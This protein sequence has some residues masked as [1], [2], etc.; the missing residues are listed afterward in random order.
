MKENE[1]FNILK[2]NIMTKNQKLAVLSNERPI[3]VSASA[4]SGK[5]FVLTTR[6]LYKILFSK[7]PTKPNKILVLTFAKSAAEEM[8]NRIINK[9]NNISLKFPKNKKINDVKNMISKNLITTIDS[10]CYNILKENFEN[11]NISPNFKIVSNLEI[12]PVKKEILNNIFE[13]EFLKNNKNFKKL[14]NYFSLTDYNVLKN[15]ILKIYDKS[16]TMPFPKEYIK[17]LIKQYESPPEFYKSEFLKEIKEDI[18]NKF[19]EIKDLLFLTINH[20]QN[21]SIEKNITSNIKETIKNIEE[22]EQNINKTKYIE[23]I[24]L[25]NNFKI[26]NFEKSENC[27]KDLIDY[28]KK[29]Y[30]NPAKKI[31]SS[32]KEYLISEEEYL[33]DF[34]QQKNIVKQLINLTLKFFNKLEIKKRKNNILEFSDLII[35]TIKLLT[36]PTKNNKFELSKIGI[37]ISKKFDEIL[38]D[39]FQDINNS[40]D[41]LIRILSNDEN[42][43]FLVG[44]LKQSIYKFRNA[45]PSIFLNKKQKYEN[46][47]EKTLINLNENFRS[48]K[49]V[50]N[51]VNFLFGQIMSSNFGGV[52][53]KNN[54]KL[55]SINK[56]K[57][58]KEYSTELHILN[59]TEKKF[60]NLEFEINHVAKT[61]KKM[62]DEEFLIYDENGNKR[63]C[64]PK[65]F[66]VLFRTGKSAIN[67][68]CEKLLNLNINYVCHNTSN[69][70][71]SF[72][73]TLL[74]SLLKTINNPLK[75]ISLCAIALSPMF[76]F[77]EL[78]LL[79]LKA[80]M[81]NEEK[82]FFTIF[83]NSKNEKCLQL[84]NFL[85]K[86]MKKAASLNLEELIEEIINSLTF[87]KIFK[88]L[89]P[90]E[91]N[92]KNL[93]LFLK[94][95]KKYEKL[96]NQGLNGFLEY[97]DNLNSENAE[98]ELKN[99]FENEN[100]VNI[101]TIHK[102]K[103]LEFPI[104]FIPLTTKNFNEEEFKSPVLITSKFGLVLKHSNE[105]SLLRYNT[106]PFNASVIFK[107]KSLKEEELRLLYVA[108]T[109]AK[110]K[111]I[112]T[113]M[114]NKKYEIIKDMNF[115]SQNLPY[116]YCSN[117]K[118]FF[119]WIFPAFLRN[120]N[121]NLFNDENFKCNINIKDKFKNEENEKLKSK[122]NV[123]HQ[124][125]LIKTIK[126][127][128]KININK[129]AKISVTDILKFENKKHL[130]KNL[131]MPNFNLKQTSSQKG[132]A[133]HMF[134]QYANFK[135]A[136][137]NLNFEINRLI[138][139]EFIKK[140]Q[141]IS[142]NK[143]KLKNFFNSKT[144][145]IIKTADFYEREK[146]FLCEINSF[147]IFNNKNSKILLQ[148]IVDCIVE[149]NNK[150]IL[151][152]YKTDIL[153]EFNLKK[154]YKKQLKLYEYAIEKTFKKPVA[155]SIIY[156]INLNKTIIL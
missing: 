126:P 141:A 52:N 105:E 94:L 152:D 6:F 110:Q 37:E 99:N 114:H 40:Q 5:T 89:N 68:L 156:S 71:Q 14:C 139:N 138:K 82:D 134:L 20:S 62:L 77:S 53:Y 16:K 80:N 133:M 112:L 146:Y 31:A 13:E 95:T 150:L 143:Q 113:S 125:K 32:L 57:Q 147:K 9:I 97:L 61:I 102:S 26:K 2:L 60:E 144:Y 119:E 100:A 15:S 151:I 132:T 50:T 93:E 18:L 17:S 96:E 84:T 46:F 155:F 117:K 122:E 136:E 127:F 69:F 41:M 104:V 83:K 92:N 8:F 58:L 11:L 56:T 75:D 129:I 33:K 87:L 108:M 116:T 109:R 39:E 135:N 154:H 59:N 66:A 91:I 54:E 85:E 34:K 10:F 121:Y 21:N 4:G 74:I 67:I 123:I 49:E 145:E 45:N 124:F 86:L 153:S 131:K 140:K 22:I 90:K 63:K 115:K 120:K 42:K 107:K 36:K 44:D 130:K 35:K 7:N 38:V 12:A 55:I 28:L 48:R 81:S 88:N 76:N 78:E 149:K 98:I 19:Q 23:L 43:L 72:E 1:I 3:L 65:D 111:I 51:S 25:L 137:K 79:N 118:N 128:K 64:E 148:G 24:N 30:I 70:L 47:K 101:M 29:T 106:L 103:G 142:L 73:I 27:S